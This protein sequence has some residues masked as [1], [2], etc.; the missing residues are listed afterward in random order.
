MAKVQASSDDPLAV[1]APRRPVAGRAGAARPAPRLG[2]DR[3]RARTRAITV[4][5]GARNSVEVLRP[6]YAQV[7][8]KLRTRWSDCVAGQPRRVADHRPDHAAERTRAVTLRVPASRRIR[9]YRRR[10]RRVRVVAVRGDT[11]RAPP[12]RAVVAMPQRS[13]G[14]G[15]HRSSGVKR[16]GTQVPERRASS[17]PEPV[18]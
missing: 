7:D 1:D 10:A 13:P 5:T 3:W 14:P 15:T 4:R 2:R 6:T 18:S 12:N 16:V 11:R 9:T 17:P 8:Q